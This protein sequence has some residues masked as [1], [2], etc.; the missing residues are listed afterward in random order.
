MELVLSVETCIIRSSMIEVFIGVNHHFCFFCLKGR[1]V[2]SK[3]K[4]PDPINF[5]A[6]VDWYMLVENDWKLNLI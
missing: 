5:N 4:S 6:W 2:T 3:H 1:R